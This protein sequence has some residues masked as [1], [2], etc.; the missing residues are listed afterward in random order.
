MLTARGVDV[1]DAVCS[2]VS[3]V[4]PPREFYPREGQQG[5]VERAFAEGFAAGG[6]SAE[7]TTALVDAPR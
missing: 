5:V 1:A 7:A 4:L 2:G 6:I 3:V